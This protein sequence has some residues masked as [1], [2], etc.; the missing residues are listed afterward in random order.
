MLLGGWILQ[1]KRAVILIYKSKVA[2]ARILLRGRR[3]WWLYIK[4][5]FERERKVP[6]R[7][8]PVSFQLIIHSIFFCLRK[9]TYSYHVSLSSTSHHYTPIHHRAH[10]LAT[11]SISQETCYRARTPHQSSCAL[12]DLYTMIQTLCSSTDNWGK[13]FPF[14]SGH[15]IVLRLQDNC[16]VDNAPPGIDLT[17][18]HFGTVRDRVDCL[19][20]TLS[21]IGRC[22]DTGGPA[23]NGGA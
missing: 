3:S 13:G 20:R 12:P 9:H 19:N 14:L 7:W 5:H 15:G 6:I 8:L 22:V 2:I 10:V 1:H 21:I 16:A 11:G 4:S 23:L 18:D 17:N